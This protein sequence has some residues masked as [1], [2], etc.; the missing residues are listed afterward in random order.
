MTKPLIGM[1]ADYRTAKQD[2]PAY[3]YVAAG[4]YDAI[5]QAGG[6]PILIPPYEC[7]QD[8]HDILDRLDAHRKPHKVGRNPRRALLLLTELLVRSPGP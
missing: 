7:E 1:N 8:V 2:V 6:L 3:S 4:Y 5:L